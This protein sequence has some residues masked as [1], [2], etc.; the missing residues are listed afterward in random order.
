MQR[1]E[2]QQSNT[3]ELFQKPRLLVLD[4]QD[5]EFWN[6][7]KSTY[8]VELACKQDVSEVLMEASR[9]AFDA[10]VLS[11]EPGSEA[12]ILNM[13][14]DIRCLSTGKNLPI[15]FLLSDATSGRAIENSKLINSAVL[16]RPLA[17]ET[18]GS[19]LMN[20]FSF[21]R[22]SAFVISE[23]P[24]VTAQLAHSLN[25]CKFRTHFTLHPDRCFEFLYDCEPE[26]VFLDVDL[27]ESDPVEL[28]REIHAS[29]VWSDSIAIMLFSSRGNR[30]A[31]ELISPCGAFGAIDFSQSIFRMSQ[32]LADIA[33]EIDQRRKAREHDSLTGLDDASKLYPQFVPLLQTEDEHLLLSVARL[34]IRKLSS[35]NATCG[36]RVGDSV[37]QL[38]SRVVSSRMEELRSFVCRYKAGQFVVVANCDK[39][40]LSSLLE[41]CIEE[42]RDSGLDGLSRPVNVNAGVAQYLVDGTSLY[43][44]LDLAMVRLSDAKHQSAAAVCT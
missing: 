8:V 1:S 35:I 30:D 44:L 42:V 19:C 41:E 21:K 4:R 39:R 15:A 18:V 9:T 22:Q 12:Q 43:V 38:V 25:E 13:A 36:N 20:L 7:H 33:G 2:L 3:V 11:V 31:S 10:A 16:H 17:V 24:Q 26:L 29:K 28:S 6:K 5:A 32:M 27:H 40:K 37:L 23:S 14:Q 34:D